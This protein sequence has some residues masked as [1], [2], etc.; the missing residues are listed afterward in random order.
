[1]LA[2]DIARCRHSII[3]VVVETVGS[4]DHC[5]SLIALQC[6]RHLG[7]RRYYFPRCSGTSRGPGHPDL[8]PDQFRQAAPDVW[9]ET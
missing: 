3:A 8:H 7:G 9:E 4:C 2:A 5:G 6:I 1:M